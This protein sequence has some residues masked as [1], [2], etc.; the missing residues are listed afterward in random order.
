MLLTTCALARAEVV[1]SVARA[2]ERSVARAR[3]VLRRVEIINLDDAILDAAALLGPSNLRTLEAIHLAAALALGEDL[4]TFVAY[5][6]RLLAG[7]AS[8]GLPI[9]APGSAIQTDE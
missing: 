7:A 9:A 1:R 6:R 3:A 2:G 5:D 8:L 4:R